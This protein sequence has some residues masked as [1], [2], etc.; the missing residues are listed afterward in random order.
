MWLLCILVIFIAPTM[1][2]KSHLANSE[3]E[4]IRYVS[5]TFLDRVSATGTLTYNDYVIYADSIAKLNKGYEV[6]VLQRSYIR[7]P[8]YDFLTANEI[9]AYYLGRNIRKN[10]ELNTDFDMPVL[11]E[12]EI[13]LL[14]EE[15]N[16]TI[17]SALAGEYVPLPE[18]GSSITNV[19]YTAVRPT[20]KVYVKESLITVCLK[21]S[22]TGYEYV[23]ADPVSI[24]QTGDRVVELTLNGVP[25]GT[26]VSVSVYPRQLVCSNGHT[27]SCTKEM[28]ANKE[29]TGVWA[30]CPYC[31][32]EVKTITFLPNTI[33]TNVGTDLVTAGLCCQVEYM[34]GHTEVVFPDAEGFTTDYD[35]SYCGTQQVRV[36]YKGKVQG[37]LT[38][39]TKGGSCIV[40]GAECKNRNDTDY[41]LEKYCEQCLAGVPFFF[42]ETYV[43]ES[44]TTMDEIHTILLQDGE[45]KFN[46]NGYLEITVYQTGETALVDG[47]TKIPV[48]RCSTIIRSQTE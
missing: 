32:I 20:Q 24:T 7:T 15:S 35:A 10:I 31:R 23:V 22:E 40:C 13:F 14:Q 30:G 34:D 29:A 21:E 27:Y 38:V 3:M 19:T 45:Y 25:L 17:F 36:S 8:Y 44:I 5:D 48:Y 18:E 6:Q 47:N 43:E 33:L 28:I 11:Q 46:R 26:S 42:G 37:G 9:A 41:M 39:T 12:E 4:Y 16:A 1:F 2:I